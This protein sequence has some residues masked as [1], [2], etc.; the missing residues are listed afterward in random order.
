MGALEVASLFASVKLDN[1]LSSP[2]K[3]VRKELNQASDDA[4][5]TERSVGGLGSALSSLG[6]V[7]ASIGIA[8]FFSSAIAGA[9][10]AAQVNAQL[11]AVLASTANST[12]KVRDSHGKLVPMM[13][14]TKESVLAT[15][16]ALMAQTGIDDDVITGAQNLLLTFTKIGKDV[17]PDA[18]AAV[19]D[20]SA[21]M[22]TDQKSAALMIGKALQSAEGVTALTRAGVQ[23]TKQE[24]N[25]IKA[26][27]A[28]GKAAEAQKMILAELAKEFGGSAAS[29]ADGITRLQTGWGNFVETVGG[30]V[31][32]VIQQVALW[33]NDLLATLTP[34]IPQIAA[35]AG[36]FALL[37][38][39][40]G[41]VGV[42]LGAM[43]G[44]IGAIGVAIAGLTIAWNEN[45]G[46]MR[47][48]AAGAWAAIKPGFD[49]ITNGIKTIFD[50][51]TTKPQ[52][53]GMSA[54][55]GEGMTAMVEGV[56]G[57][58][59]GA[60]LSQAIQA[61]MPQVID[62]F[63]L[64][65]Q[66]AYTWLS[67]DGLKMVQDGIKAALQFATDAGA[68][69]TAN[70]PN[71][72]WGVMDWL[73]GARNWLAENGPKAISEGVQGALNFSSSIVQFVADNAPDLTFAIGGW[74]GSAVDWLLVE[75]PM[76]IQNAVNGLFTGV[77]VD[78]SG[79]MTALSAVF[80]ADG[81]IWALFDGL[82][83]AEKGTIG[84]KVSEFFAEGG[85]LSTLIS[86]AGVILQ[87]TWDQLFG[88]EG[89][90]MKTVNALGGLVEG[91]FNV[92]RTKVMSILK[93]LLAPIVTLL[94]AVWLVFNALND[95][96]HADAVLSS[97]A[98]IEGMKADGGPVRRGKNYIV[99]ERG[100]EVF[101]P[102][103]N[104]SIITNSAAFG[105]GG[106]SMNIAAVYI[107]GTDNPAVFFDRM[108]AEA[109]RRNM[110]LGT[111]M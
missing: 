33:L 22:H 94:K 98:A 54:G 5:N 24:E 19:L 93:G 46:G 82:F 31:L 87:A 97:I 100:P 68:W 96:E 57:R 78:G 105:G 41:P 48:A 40:T 51:F 42:I 39:V 92:M 103:T 74:I 60:K 107:S 99:G 70:A 45:L 56:D 108:Q 4:K 44:P 85:I 63:K 38:T 69:I 102:D 64:L 101:T 95:R 18:T 83:G 90:F 23:F 37:A 104:G 106:A 8:G 43:L 20:M 73:D 30:V 15:S 53:A 35:A 88:K 66:G 9:R 32:P 71:I 17:M 14:S 65:L 34:F 109:K 80:A 12:I 79:L 6:S 62:G 49:A 67:T 72:I 86:D 110:T 52:V 29:Q 11:D 26:L 77:N 27:F 47:D 2:L 10:E 111:A 50:V 25:K 58:S 76:M 61:G 89:G 7:A 13:R 21:A 28:S 1:K 91:V 84:L 59:F 75:A 36:A 16:A 55:F 81:P 3:D